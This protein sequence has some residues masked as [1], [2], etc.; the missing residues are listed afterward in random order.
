MGFFKM[1][2][3]T[4]TLFYFIIF[5]PLLFAVQAQDSLSQEQVLEWVDKSPDTAVTQD[6][7]EPPKCQRLD[8]S[9]LKEHGIHLDGFMEVAAGFRN[10]SIS[11]KKSGDSFIKRLNHLAAMGFDVEARCNARIEA[12]KS[13][14]LHMTL[15]VSRGNERVVLESLREKETAGGFLT[16]EKAL[17]EYV[18][19]SFLG[20]EGGI[21]EVPMSRY[22]RAFKEISSVWLVRSDFYTYLVPTPWYDAGLLVKGAVRTEKYLKTEW[23]VGL[24]NGLD[25]H[26]SGGRGFEKARQ[27]IGAD[28]NRGKALSGRLGFTILEK[29]GIAV[30][31]YSG[32]A[33]IFDHHTLSMGMAELFFNL[34]FLRVEAGLVE[35]R[36]DSM[37]NTQNDTLPKEMNGKYAELYG[38]YFLKKL[39][40]TL[41]GAIG[42]E[43]LCLD[44]T[45]RMGGDIGFPAERWI[46]TF[47]LGFRP[48]ERVFIKIQMRFPKN[49]EDDLNPRYID[50]D[51]FLFG[52]TVG[53]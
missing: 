5:S 28:N 41:S 26:I 46:Y 44:K 21:I 4:K 10:S 30:S 53:W 13:L 22:N 7:A 17:V 15:G 32:D 47:A 31:G 29:G 45:G 8:K 27:G 52:V 36:L 51:I 39:K 11:D 9:G 14:S 33:D 6:T 35:C 38:D 2:S 49:K 42:V 40:G 16:L 24:T 12:V 1:G 48:H 25:D 37:V 3:K 18:P 20:L 34:K 43:H 19:Y 50:D 23:I